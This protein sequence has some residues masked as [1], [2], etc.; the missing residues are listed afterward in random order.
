[1]QPHIVLKPSLNTGV[2][3]TGTTAV[4]LP[5]PSTDVVAAILIIETN[6]CRMRC[7]G[8]NSQAGVGGGILMKKDSVWEIQGRDIL[9]AMTFVPESSA[10]YVSVLYLKG[11]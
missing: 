5:S 11:E 9:S 3:F 6:D 2:T 1:L 8:T 7:D 4:S 10:G